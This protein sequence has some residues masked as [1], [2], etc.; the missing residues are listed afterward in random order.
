MTHPISPK[1]VVLRWAAAKQI[2][3]VLKTQYGKKPVGLTVQ[4]W[5]G[6]R[7]LPGGA[8]LEFNIQAGSLRGAFWSKSGGYADAIEKKF[9]SMVAAAGFHK[10][11]ESSD[12][13]PADFYV[14]SGV[15]Y[16]D[17]EGNELSFSSSYG[18]TKSSNH[19]RITLD[20]KHPAP[21]L[22]DESQTERDEESVRA[23]RT[24]LSNEVLSSVRGLTVGKDAWGKNAHLIGDALLPDW[25]LDEEGGDQYYSKKQGVIYTNAPDWQSPE[26]A[27]VVYVGGLKKG[28]GSLRIEKKYDA[29][30]ARSL[31]QAVGEV[32]RELKS[33][34]PSAAK[35]H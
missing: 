14:A 24:A 30:D 15:I 8:G 25:I 23:S 13:H 34:K 6:L 3:K 18:Q 31:A 26:A 35:R 32:L 27:L 7:L 19:F 21:I 12:A 20:F 33:S 17:S 4:Q 28:K 1:T 11:S 2:V 16:A 29:D 22:D 10:K 9:Y 5:E